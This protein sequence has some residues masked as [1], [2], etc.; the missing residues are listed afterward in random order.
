METANNKLT[1][2]GVDVQKKKN[3]QVIIFIMTEAVQVSNLELGHFTD[4]CVL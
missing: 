4:R 3:I 1:Q 2:T